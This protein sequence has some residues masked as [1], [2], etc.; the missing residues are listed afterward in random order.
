MAAVSIAADPRAVQAPVD[1]AGGQPGWPPRRPRDEGP[2][3]EIKAPA[4]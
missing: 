2:A 4:E 1:C 3:I